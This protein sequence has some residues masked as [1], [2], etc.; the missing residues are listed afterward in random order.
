MTAGASGY[1]LKSNDGRHIVR[2]I[3]LVAEGDVV[4]DHAVAEEVL[5]ELPDHSAN[6]L[7]RGILTDG[8]IEILR[9]LSDGRTNKEIAHQLRVSPNTVK[10]RVGRLF[11]KLGAPDRAAAVAEGFRRHAIE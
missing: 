10:G 7:P 6:G 1:L 3:R 4:I 11:G 8:E 9:L 5:R 2:V